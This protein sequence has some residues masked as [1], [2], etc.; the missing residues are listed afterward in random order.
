MN[1]NVPPVFE[2]QLDEY[3]HTEKIDVSKFKVKVLC[4]EPECF[5]FRFVKE[6]D[7]W[8]SRYCKPHTR[9]HRL[10]YRATKAKEKRANDRKSE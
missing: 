10:R 2:T 7:A 6:Q 8:Q 9:M 5:S 3:G 4:S 1:N